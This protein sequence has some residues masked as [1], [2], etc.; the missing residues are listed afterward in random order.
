MTKKYNKEEHKEEK[1]QR[2]ECT[3]EDCVQ[4]DVRR[5]RTLAWLNAILIIEEAAKRDSC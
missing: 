1:Q 5:Q 4:C 2:E 3:N